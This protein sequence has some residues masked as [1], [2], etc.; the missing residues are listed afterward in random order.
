MCA[1]GLFAE[2]RAAALNGAPDPE[3]ALAGLDSAR[4]YLAPLFLCAGHGL[5]VV[6][7]RA[8]GLDGPAA[9]RGGQRRVLCP[10]LG[11]MP[12]L[13]RLILARAAE[14]ARSQGLDP[15]AAALLLVGHGSPRNP[16]SR[17]AAEWHAAGARAAAVFGEVDIALLDEPPFLAE[18]MRRLTRPTIAVGL[19]A[20]NNRHAGQGLPD[21]I[22]RHAPVVVRYLGAIGTDVG[23]PDLV[24]DQVAATAS[25]HSQTSRT[26][27]V[28]VRELCRVPG[29]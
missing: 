28:A 8:L 2:V 20:D 16:A 24:L 27:A 7:P 3:A 11:L 5:R 4:V 15:E 1:R 29:W 9:R 14:A 23:I 21:A 13:T 18:V 25:P 17:R 10:P 12:G 19:F 22:A 6:L 26:Q